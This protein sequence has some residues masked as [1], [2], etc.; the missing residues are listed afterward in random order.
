M[1]PGYSMR[2]LRDMRNPYQ[3]APE[4]SIVRTDTCMGGQLSRGDDWACS[5]RPQVDCQSIEDIT[6]GVLSK[7]QFPFDTT[8]RM[9]HHMTVRIPGINIANLARKGMCSTGSQIGRAHV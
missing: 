3:P 4:V 5:F 9:G 8:C 7:P 6:I 1:A 2:S